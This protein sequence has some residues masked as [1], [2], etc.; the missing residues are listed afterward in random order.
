[1]R[2]VKSFVA[3]S[4]EA[5]RYE[6]LIGSPDHHRCWFPT[7]A[8]ETTYRLG[9]IKVVAGAGFGTFIFGFGFAAMYCSLWVGFGQVIDGEMSFGDLMA[10]QSYIFTIG[11]GLAGLAANIT[12]VFQAKGASQRIF[13]LLQ[14]VPRIPPA[15][16]SPADADAT[17]SGA[18]AHGSV[19]FEGVDF[20]YPS[21]SDLP[22]LKGFDLSVEEN[23]QVAL[24]GSS[25]S[26][27][28]TGTK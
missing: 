11:G 10:F 26:G 18:I 8:E 22:V 15:V 16:P 28:S 17:A 5:E 4:A 24:C 25:G 12:N 13:E 7:T 1:M 14:R 6:H 21:R 20:A 3:E 23:T 27:K 9:A 19:L 2:T